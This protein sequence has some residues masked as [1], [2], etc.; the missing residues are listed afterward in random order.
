[1]EF[2]YHGGGSIVE[3]TS[4]G[5]RRDPLAMARVSQATGLNVVMGSGWYQ[6]LYHPADMD[7]RT[8]EDMTDEIIRDVTV[9]VG[10]T[11]IRSGII[12]EVAS[13]AIRSRRTRS[14]AYGHPAGPAAPPEPPSHSTAAARD[15]KDWR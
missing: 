2:R 12:G 13:R 7:Q 1:M 4:I 6:K 9:G 8:V 15:G 3:V 5:I 14:R 11:A 10:G